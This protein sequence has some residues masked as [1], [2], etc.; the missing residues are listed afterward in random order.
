MPCSGCNALG[1]ATINLAV[2]PTTW[3]LYMIVLQDHSQ[4]S[5]FL[6]WL[7]TTSAFILVACLYDC[8]SSCGL[9]P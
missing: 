2:L 6:R 3:S 9:F 8:L 5:Q 1:S 7:L 4:F